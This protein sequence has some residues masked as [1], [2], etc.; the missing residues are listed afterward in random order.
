MIEKL[1]YL[2]VL[3]ILAY[4]YYRRKEPKIDEDLRRFSGGGG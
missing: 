4:I 1:Y 2:C 3:H